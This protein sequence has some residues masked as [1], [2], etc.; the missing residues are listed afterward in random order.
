MRYSDSSCVVHIAA[1]RAYRSN[2]RGA[3]CELNPLY[4]VDYRSD[5]LRHTERLITCFM[6]LITPGRRDA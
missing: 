1:V 2:Q 3:L 4:L 6:C 5:E